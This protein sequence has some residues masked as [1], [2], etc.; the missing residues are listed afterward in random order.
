MVEIETNILLAARLSRTGF[1]ICLLES[2]QKVSVFGDLTIPLKPH[3][4][5]TFWHVDA[6][7]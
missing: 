3:L 4:T 5:S 7:L 2:L 6:M 1:V